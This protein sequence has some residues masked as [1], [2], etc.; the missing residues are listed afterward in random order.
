MH[1]HSEGKN[2]VI[3]IVQKGSYNAHAPYFDSTSKL[4]Y[5]ELKIACSHAERVFGHNA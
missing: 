5:T 4:R 1:L 2:S 3:V